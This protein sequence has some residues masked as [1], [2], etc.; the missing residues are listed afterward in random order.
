M[1][2]AHWVIFFFCSNSELA[3]SQE[4]WFFL[5][6][7]DTRNQDLDADM[8]VDTGVSLLLF[9]VSVCLSDKHSEVGNCYR[10]C[11]LSKGVKMGWPV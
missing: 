1:F 8:L 5:V 3:I 4:S 11:S 7:N 6:D 2:Q 10:K 9:D